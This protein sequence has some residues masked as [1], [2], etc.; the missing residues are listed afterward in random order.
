MRASER[1]YARVRAGV[2]ECGRAGERACGRA[3][4]RVRA[5][6]HEFSGT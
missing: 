1:M 3:G 5:C 6:V 4:V 2:W